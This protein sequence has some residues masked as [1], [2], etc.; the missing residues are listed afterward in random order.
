M[1]G[2]QRAEKRKEANTLQPI[3]QIG[4]G[5]IGENLVHSVDEALEKRELIKLSVLQTAGISAK[6]AAENIAAATHAEVIQCIGHKFV[7]YR[8][9]E[10]KKPGEQK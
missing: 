6:D 2:A 5:D 8:E 4:K 1:T 9:S 7:L 10:K 3:F